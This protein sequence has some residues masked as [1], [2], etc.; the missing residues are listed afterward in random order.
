MTVALKDPANTYW[1]D[2]N[3]NTER[4]LKYVIYW[5]SSES[6]YNTPPSIASWQKGNDGAA[7]WFT[8]LDARGV[9]TS[10]QCSYT[11]T[12]LKNLEPGTHTATFTVPDGDYYTP[13]SLKKTFRVLPADARPVRI[14][15]YVELNQ[16]TS[17]VTGLT[18]DWTK[19]KLTM[20]FAFS[21]SVT[22]T[23]SFG[24]CQASDK[25]FIYGAYG[26]SGH[27]Q[28]F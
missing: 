15:E 24:L 14:Y 13:L 19:A 28:I 12:A 8:G 6:S 1:A 23:W 10:T 25:F 4:K 3:T 7:V 21:K 2:T 5:V 11:K 9:G 18:P 16:D 22:Q 26:D 27:N 20:T 17:F